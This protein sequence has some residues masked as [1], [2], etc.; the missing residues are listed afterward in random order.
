MENEKLLVEAFE[1]AARSGYPMHRTTDHQLSHSVYLFDPDGNQ[2]EIYTDAKKEWWEMFTG[3]DIELIS[4][5]WTPGDPPPTTDRRYHVNPEITRVEEVPFHPIRIARGVLVTK[6]FDL[7]R[8]FVTDLLGLV[9][10]YASP[11]ADFACYRG[12]A[13]EFDLALFALENGGEAG[14]H[15]V[16]FELADESDLADAKDKLATAGITVDF[17][18]DNARKRSMFLRDPSGTGVEF[19]ADRSLNFDAIDQAPAARRPYLA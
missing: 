6:R 11:D 14:L 15:H 18:V 3:G 12:G 17:E 4:G 2:H 9:E 16:S 7:M 19:Y 1:R 5:E 8:R 10:I 13:S